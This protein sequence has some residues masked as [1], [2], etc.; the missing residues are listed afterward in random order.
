MSSRV[1]TDYHAE[2]DT[3]VSAGKVFDAI[4]NVTGW[5]TVN[6]EGSTKNLNDI[7][8]VRFG[9]T[10]SRIQITEIIPGKKI[11]WKVLDCNLHWMKDKKEWKD[12]SIIWE[13]LPVKNATRVAMTHVGLR[14]GIECYEDCRKGWNHYVKESLFRLIGED[15]GVP[16]HKDFSALERQ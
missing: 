6:I 7:F 4:N 10:Y 15:R 16:D 13:V 9:E 11:V 1:Q 5:W 14:P 2:I 12:T 8:I 3:P